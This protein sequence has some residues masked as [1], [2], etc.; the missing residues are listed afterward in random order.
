MPYLEAANHVRNEHLSGEGLCDFMKEPSD[1]Q[2]SESVHYII[3]VDWVVFIWGHFSHFLIIQKGEDSQQ[4]RGEKM[5]TKQTLKSNFL[6][7][8]N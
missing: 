8:N 4:E 5:H 1:A 2:I 6:T 3:K 7:C